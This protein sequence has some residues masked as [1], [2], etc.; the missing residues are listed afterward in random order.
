MD[1]PLGSVYAFSV[2]LRPIELELGI[3][4]SALSLVF[5]LTTLGFTVGSVSAV[6]LYRAAPAPILVLASA[7]LGAGGLA[8]AATASA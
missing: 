5:G 6:F 4:R 7:L 8:T 1:L 3:P 2:L